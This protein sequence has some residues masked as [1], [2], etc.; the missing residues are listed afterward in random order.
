MSQPQPVVA[1]GRLDI[2][3]HC[4]EP[5]ARVEGGRP[6][7]Q[8]DAL[9]AG[10]LTAPIHLLQSGPADVVGIRLRTGAAAAL[11]RHPAAELHNRVE[12]LSLLAPGL[13]DGL[14]G[15]AHRHRSPD[16]RRTALVEVLSRWVLTAP[17]ALAMAAVR[18]LDCPS[19]PAV[20][21]LAA[22]LGVGVRS[23]ERRVG[24]ATGLAPRTLVRTLRFRRVFR[25]LESAAPG[26]MTRVALNAGYFDQAH[27]VREFRR[28]AGLAPTDFFRHG[29]T[30]ATA[31]LEGAP[32]R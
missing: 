26:T 23:L 19:P 17:D 9:L 8:A 16:A 29:P 24:M 3:L 27:C 5:F 32:A 28:F 4:A 13:R 1:D 31:F 15:A 25:Q 2:I 22:S 18:Q 6:C 20:T 11:F 21:A 14:L 12:P 10:Q 30:L 7:R